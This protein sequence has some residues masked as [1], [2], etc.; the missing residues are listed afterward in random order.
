MFIEV[1]SL[2][3]AKKI[4]FARIKNLAGVKT[5]TIYPITDNFVYVLKNQ[6]DETGLAGAKALKKLINTETPTVL[7]LPHENKNDI[8]LFYI[9]EGELSRYEFEKSVEPLIA[10]LMSD[11]IKNEDSKINLLVMEDNS[12]IIDLVEKTFE[13]IYEIDSSLV[14]KFEVDTFNVKFNKNDYDDIIKETS[15]SEII[16]SFLKNYREKLNV[17][18]AISYI[19]ENKRVALLL[20]LAVFTLFLSLGIKYYKKWKTQQEIAKIQEYIVKDTTQNIS[21][22]FSKFNSSIAYFIASIPFSTIEIIDGAVKGFLDKTPDIEL[23]GFQVS[24]LSNYYAIKGKIKPIY[25]FSIDVDT[26]IDESK[27]PSVYEKDS[28]RESFVYPLLDRDSFNKIL[29]RVS[30]EKEKKISKLLSQRFKNDKFYLYI[31]LEKP[32]ITNEL[33]GKS[34]VN[35]PSIKKV[36]G[37]ER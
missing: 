27:L 22:D 5:V 10:F 18:S 8:Y 2:S 15:V 28:N 7:I 14:N 16:L 11:D 1:P 35:N 4:A 31:V 34:G 29:Y 12:D 17:N 21:L 6:N 26:N 23:K 36:S 32:E 9:K 37:V 24:K 19:K 13:A 30:K 33:K 3:K 20:S 25:N